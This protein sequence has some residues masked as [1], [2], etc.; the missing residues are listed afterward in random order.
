MG[1]LLTKRRKDYGNEAETK[2]LLMNP[3]HD[4]A[5]YYVYCRTCDKRAYGEDAIR[6]HPG[7]DWVIQQTK[8]GQRAQKNPSDAERRPA[9]MNPKKSHGHRCPSCHRA[10]PNPMPN[11]GTYTCSHCQATLRVS[12]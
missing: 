3:K 11:P 9:L 6:L 7:H 2:P 5:G 10:L 12:A 1:E 8:Q 4:A